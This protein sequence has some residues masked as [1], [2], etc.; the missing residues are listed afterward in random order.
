MELKFLTP[1]LVWADYD[2]TSTP[3]ETTIL[4]NSQED[5]FVRTEYCFT[6]ETTASGRVR[7]NSLV[8][9][10]SRW[11]D[12]RPAIIVL[13]TLH[14]SVNLDTICKGL[15]KI[16]YVAIMVDYANCTTVGTDRTS[17]P[18]ELSYAEFPACESYMNDIKTSAKETPWVVWAK[19]A[20]RA[21][22]FA[23]EHRLV[24]KERIGLM[25]F[26]TGGN[27]SWITA[28]VDDRLKA[29]IP[30]DAGGYLWCRDRKRFGTEA[31]PKT[32]EESA[33]ST[34]VGAETY[35]RTVK[36]PIFLVLSSNS[37]YFDIDRSGDIFTLV[38]AEN[39]HLLISKN[40]NGQITSATLQCVE[41]WLSKYLAH[42]NRIISNPTA[43][44]DVSEGHIML[45]LNTGSSPTNIQVYLSTGKDSSAVRSWSEITDLQRIGTNNYL[46]KI[47]IVDQDEYITAF[48]NVTYT[49]GIQYSTPVIAILPSKYGLTEN[50]SI[51]NSA[52]RI[53]YNGSM[54]LGNFIVESDSFIIAD[55]SLSVKNGPFNIKGISTNI[56]NLVL[57]RSSYETLSEDKNIIFRFDA[58]SKESRTITVSLISLTNKETYSTDINLKGGEHWQAVSLDA[59][60]FKNN[61]GK[62]LTRFSEI[63]KF[64]FSGAENVIFN[65]ILWV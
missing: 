22:S 32:D 6:S 9:Y 10:D 56:G 45:H 1:T 4:S 54:G 38:P 33:F 37:D 64:V 18:S 2:P 65:N 35:A 34:G 63:N 16:G 36:C 40:T 27:I 58:Y 50:V 48:A 52:S 41:T 14:N 49:K 31:I 19:I 61:K 21:I 47:N 43:S 30:I 15:V 29:V 8:Y 7:V 46:A 25:G 57:F 20:R 23:K 60:S 11:V 42:D 62:S 17:F 39:K 44:F 59:Q 51:A 28:G 53:I 5:N 26:G 12:Q 3:L 24:L 13:P 55:D